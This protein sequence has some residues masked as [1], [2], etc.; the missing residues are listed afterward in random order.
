MRDVP[1]QTS[2]AD[3][4]RSAHAAAGDHALPETAVGDDIQL[5]TRRWTF[6][7]GTAAHFDQ[8]VAKSVP[9]YDDG[10]A[11]V[12]ELSDFFVGDGGRIIEVGC[13]TG[14]L[15]SRLARRHE[16]V[17][18]EFLGVDV[19]DDMVQ[20]ARERCKDQANVHIEIVDARRVDY[21]DACLVV[22]YYTLQFIPLWQ[23]G[24]LL[25]R[26]RREMRLGGAIILFEKTRLPDGMLQDICN[27]VYDTYKLARGFSA[28]EVLGKT[29]SLRGVLQPSTSAENMALLRRAGFSEPHVIYRQ[30]AFEGLVAVKPFVDATRG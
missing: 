14:T 25:E 29:R 5:P 16:A 8:H 4:D 22:M 30:L 10:H 24:A 19:A 20:V 3:A 11:L 1:V 7:R 2:D 28:E 26:I 12:E 15:I 18:A 17:D 27:Q 23:R 6:G 13:S 9:G 21:T